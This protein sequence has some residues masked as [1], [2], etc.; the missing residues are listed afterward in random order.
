M[1]YLEYKDYQGTVAFSASD[2]CLHGRIVGI[3]DLVTYEA[4]SIDDLN[5]A[6]RD[7]V[8]D[9]LAMCAEAGRAPDRKYSGKVMLRM[10]QELHRRVA[11][12]A[13]L[14][15]KSLNAWIAS[16]LDRVSRERHAKRA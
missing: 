10:N 2:E 15:G 13:A 1:D 5:A 11:M 4:Q 9:Y 14:E 12:Q 6:F 7:S 8:D 3:E 16:E